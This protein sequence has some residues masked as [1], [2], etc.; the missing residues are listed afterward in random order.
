M[1]FNPD[2]EDPLKQAQRGA[3]CHV[4][5]TDKCDLKC[6]YCGSSSSEHLV[7]SNIKYTIRSLQDFLSGVEELA[8]AFYGGEH[9]P[10]G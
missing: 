3:L 7:P 1:S 5:T 2:A 8:I 10:H 9:S 6:D 4:L